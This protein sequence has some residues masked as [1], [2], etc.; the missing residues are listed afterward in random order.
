VDAGPE[1][2]DLHNLTGSSPDWCL[3]VRKVW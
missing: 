2:D 3:P 1:A